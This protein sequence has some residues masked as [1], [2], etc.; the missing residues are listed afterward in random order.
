MAKMSVKPAAKPTAKPA[1]KKPIRSM[2][3]LKKVAK[4]KGC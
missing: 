2:E 4:K 3:D 1:P